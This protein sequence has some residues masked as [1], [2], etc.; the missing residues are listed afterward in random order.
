M[1]KEFVELHVSIINDVLG[2][3]PEEQFSVTITSVSDPRIVIGP[4]AETCI[5]IINDD[6]VCTELLPYMSIK[7]VALIIYQFETIQ[8]LK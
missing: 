7:T 2:N 1:V 3:E 4:N 5:N 8:Y 6:S